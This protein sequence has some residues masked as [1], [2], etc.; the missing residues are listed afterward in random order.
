MPDYGNPLQFGYFLIPDAAEYPALVDLAQHADDLGL[1][2]IGIQDHPYQRRFLDTWTLL[3]AIGVQTKRVR[4]FPDVANLPLRPPAVL[5]KAA[6]S[7]DLMT[8]GRFELGLG[9]GGF[10]DAIAAIGGPRRTPGEAVLATEE[11][12]GVMRLL[13]SDQRAI[14][15]EGR[16]YSLHGV[17]P[18]PLPAH[19]IQIWIGASGP[20]MLDLIGRAADG[21]LPSSS[22]I[23][24]ARLPELNSRID[25][26]ATLAGRPPAA[27]RRLYNVMGR[28][29]SRPSAG[30]LDGPVVQWVDELSELAR[31]HGMD[32]FIFAPAGP[33]VDQLRLFAAE[34]APQVRERVAQRRASRD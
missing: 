2:L 32:T 26:A 18:G 20:R 4:V 21:W 28:I 10:W 11:A 3:T 22:Y 7:L 34:V 14:S 25:A 27:V 1:D 8:G 5:A 12:I 17:H 23:P 6:A 33:P 30:F 29:G 13:W 24:P 16:M 9:A 15:F 31:T 19:P